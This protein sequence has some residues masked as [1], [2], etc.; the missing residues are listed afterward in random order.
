MNRATTMQS[1]SA[2]SRSSQR[3]HTPLTPVATDKAAVIKSTGRLTDAAG[4]TSK[5]PTAFNAAI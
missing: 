3:R 2:I 4:W 1:E 5:K